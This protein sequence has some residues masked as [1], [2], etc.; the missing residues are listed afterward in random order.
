[1]S[2]GF[3]AHLQKAH[4]DPQNEIHRLEAA[5]TRLMEQVVSKE[6]NIADLKREKEAA[7]QDA[8]ER[9][10][11]LETLR[12]RVAELESLFDEQA[13]EEVSSDRVVAWV[14]A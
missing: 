3:I 7:I 4:R 13:V 10:A 12:K 1:M 11:E 8:V 14:E 6:Y 5:N 2:R 9:M